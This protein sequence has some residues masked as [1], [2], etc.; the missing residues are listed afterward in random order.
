[1]SWVKLDDRFFDNTKIVA[2][3]AGAK[4]AYL[5]GLTYC[6]RELT[7]GFIPLNKA[8]V[9]A[10]PAHVKEL[11]LALWEQAEGGYRVHDYL[12]YNPS[13]AEALA[14]K[15]EISQTRSQAGSK[16]AAKRWQTDGK[17]DDPVARSPDP[18]PDP[19]PPSPLLLAAKGAWENR[20]GILPGSFREEFAE[21]AERVPAEWFVGAIEVT[22]A[23][24]D[25]PNW[26]FCRAVLDTA[27]SENTPP[28]LASEAAPVF[29][30]LNDILKRRKPVA[31][32][33]RR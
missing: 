30:S 2:L 26:K 9:I 27:L 15:Q 33:R 7:D 8:K 25:R 16:G 4:I 32:G 11:T 10:R 5:E 21:Y 20:I 29:T 3:T 24:A 19:E 28:R 31:A 12:D 14:R 13:K 18:S 1:M 22:R 17:S 6:A 23:E